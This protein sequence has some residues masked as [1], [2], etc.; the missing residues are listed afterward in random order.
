M[1]TIAEEDNFSYECY[2]NGKH[3]ILSRTEINDKAKHYNYIWDLE[4]DLY[5]WNIDGYKDRNQVYKI[6]GKIAIE[7]GLLVHTRK[8]ALTIDDV[9]TK[10]YN[11]EELECSTF[12]SLAAKFNRIFKGENKKKILPRKLWP[13]HHLEVIRTKVSM[14]ARPAYK[15]H[16]GRTWLVICGKVPNTT[17]K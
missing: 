3:V 2:D 8:K 14:T 6:T 16:F 9:E 12:I 7:F 15:M 17:D 11:D 10:L 4:S 13:F 1:I 5:A